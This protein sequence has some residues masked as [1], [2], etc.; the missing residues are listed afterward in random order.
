MLLLTFLGLVATATCRPAWYR[1]PAIDY[2][3]LKTDK[4]D[5][6][7]LVDAIGTALNA[8]REI[9]FELPEEQLNRWIAARTEFW[10]GWEDK[11]ADFCYPQVSLLT[12]NRVRIAAN[13]SIGPGEV[14]LWLT[15]CWELTDEQLLIHLESAR[16]GI[17][18]IPS[19][20]FLETIR[21]SLER[22]PVA[23]ATVSGNTIQID[24]DWVWENGKCPFRFRR[25]DISDGLVSIALEPVRGGP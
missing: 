3:H 24:N 23:S 19:S 17:L 4:R 21:R 18:P 20:R 13:V 7:R 1:P 15:G 8:G 14:I 2:E 5:F 16:S 10:P 22:W 25:L 11:L 12:K 9:E 6:V